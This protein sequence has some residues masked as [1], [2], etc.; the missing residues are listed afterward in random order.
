MFSFPIK[1]TVEELLALERKYPAMAKR[2]QWLRSLKTNPNISVQSLVNTVGATEFEMDRW[3]AL[4]RFGGIELLVNP[5]TILNTSAIQ[6]KTFS[7][8]AQDMLRELYANHK[9]QL[10]RQLWIDFDNCR[11]NKPSG[12]DCVRF[13]DYKDFETQFKNWRRTDCQTYIQD[14]IRYSYEKTGRRNIYDGLLNFYKSN[15]VTGTIMAQYLVK[16]GWKA[17]LFMPD[18]EQPSD[19]NAEHTQKYR[20]AIKT[21]SWWKVPLAGFIVNYKPTNSGTSGA[22]PITSDGK[23]K[24]AALANVKF[25]ACVFTKGIHTGILSEGNILEVH[26]KNISEQSKIDAKYQGFQTDGEG[27]LYESTNLLDFSWIEGIFVIPPDNTVSL[28]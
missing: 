25:A 18:T 4:Y 8:H 27:K 2:L 20:D 19:S 11:T 16:Q 13:E 15:G 12:T 24:L 28:A 14:V 22:T 1:E 9:E 6:T 3:A 21:N 7:D 5:K 26:W 10:G 17:Y 23:R